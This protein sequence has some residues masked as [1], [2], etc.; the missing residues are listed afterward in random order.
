MVRPRTSGAIMKTTKES[1]ASMRP[2]SAR[3]AR[4]VRAQ[5]DR[6]VRAAQTI[7]AMQ[8]AA[9]SKTQAEADAWAEFYMA[10][11]VIEAV[12]A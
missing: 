6:L 7:A 2:S 12:P 10:I 4:V 11:N 9:R 3:R 8:P 1:C 5:R